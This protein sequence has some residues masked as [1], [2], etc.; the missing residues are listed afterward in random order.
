MLSDM[1]RSLLTLNLPSLST[2]L[3]G[4]LLLVGVGSA[5][6]PSAFAFDDP[7]APAALLADLGT[8][9]TRLNYEGVVVYQRGTELSTLRVV[10]RGQPGPEAER[11]M[12]LDGPAREVVR[13]DGQVRCLFADARDASLAQRAPSNPLRFEAGFDLEQVDELYALETLGDARIAGRSAFVVA[14]TP[15]EATRY[16]Y[17]F[18][19]DAETR[20]LLMSEVLDSV[21][22]VLER[23]RFVEIR[24]PSVVA[25]EALAPQLD[26]S[27]AV[28]RSLAD[29]PASKASEV[30]HR[31]GPTST[32]DFRVGWL[33]RGFAMRESK[34]AHLVDDAQPVEHKVFGDGLAMVSVFVEPTAPTRALPVGDAP[35]P[36]QAEFT[37]VGAMNAVSR[38][39]K[40][41]RVTVVGE[42]P[43]QAIARI[44]ASV[45]RTN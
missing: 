15:L 39:E 33:P 1:V 12:S 13:A 7:P 38:V 36:Q 8:A 27:L 37:S 30:S 19:V 17:L 20:M 32:E 3:L 31:A 40:D 21:G 25:A 42:L 10:H 23:T 34:T 2:R 35:E 18:F 45:G 22:N 6:A 24:F 29:E 5:L 4:C 14:I 11:I 28:T 9:A 16:G 26:A 43:R 44:A 41:Y